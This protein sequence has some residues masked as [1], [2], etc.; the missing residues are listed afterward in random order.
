MIDNKKKL[1]FGFLVDSI[2]M[3]LLRHVLEGIR[4]SCKANNIKLLIYTGA[5]SY[6]K[7]VTKALYNLVSRYIYKLDVDGLMVFT[8][9]IAAHK[10]L[11]YVKKIVMAIKDIPV[12]SISTE[13]PGYSSI[14]V[15]NEMGI[16]QIFDHLHNDHGFKRIAFIKGPKDHYES[17]LRYNTYCNSLYKYGISL[18]ENIIIQGERF[19]EPTGYK[20]AKKLL[21]NIKNIDAIMAADDYIAIGAIKCLNDNN[22]SVPNDITVTGFDNIVTTKFSK[23]TLTTVEQPFYN[24][25]VQSVNCMMNIINYGDKKE[26]IKLPTKLIL[27]DSCCFSECKLR[28]EDH[29]KYIDLNKFILKKSEKFIKNIIECLQSNSLKNI[30]HLTSI[31][32]TRLLDDYNK[33]ISLS[34]WP[35]IIK[36]LFSRLENKTMSWDFKWALIRTFNEILISF[37]ELEKQSKN[38]RDK[39]ELCSLYYLAHEIL[40][41]FNKDEL[42]EI[43]YMRLLEFNIKNFYLC[44]YDREYSEDEINKKKELPIAT[45]QLVHN[46]SLNI[47]N[48]KGLNISGESVLSDKILNVESELNFYPIY[49]NSIHFGYILFKLDKNVMTELYDLLRISIGSALHSCYIM[50]KL[51]N[52]VKHKTNFLI[53]LTHEMKTPLTI[54]SSYLGKYILE[55]KDLNDISI[56]INNVDKL[57]RDINNILDYE[58]LD[59]G[60]VHY[61]NLQKINLSKY[62]NQK[63]TSF[64]E[65]IKRSRIT[66]IKNIRNTCYIKM[67]PAALD[68]VLNNLIE[69]AIKYNIPDGVIGVSLY[70][71]DNYIELE[72]FNTGQLIHKSDESRIFDPFYQKNKEKSN[73]DGIGMGLSLVREIVERANCSIKLKSKDEKTCFVVRFPIANHDRGI[74]KDNLVFDIKIP[75]TLPSQSNKPKFDPSNNTILIVEDNQQMLHFLQSQLNPLYNLYSSYSANE[76]LILLDKIPKPDIIISDMMMDG[77]SGIDFFELLQRKSRFNDI[78]FLFLSANNRLETKIQ[79]LKMGAVDY[80]TKPFRLQLLL[81]KIESLLKLY[82]IQKNKAR[83]KLKKDLY[84]FLDDDKNNNS[85]IIPSQLTKIFAKRELDAIK[86]IK[87][88]MLYKEIASEMDIS[89]NT[90]KTYMKRIY[91]KAGVNNKVELLNKLKWEGNSL[92]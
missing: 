74:E 92:V 67:D 52:S 50:N 70:V 28:Q 38:D 65:I 15:D 75:P 85:L 11:D 4:S 51:E 90:L 29:V 55:P 21:N 2:D 35:I 76:A 61:N 36:E 56:V 25:G 39:K 19:G 84:L 14:L 40:S 68:R 37:L 53:N 23:P 32:K 54:I 46:E 5:I 60:K 59:K 79:A 13:I 27:R 63:L 22:I 33:Q 10:G 16:S 31:L 12:I 82:N 57:T 1:R 71:V 49:F 58:R 8:G 26:V 86:Y 80:I 17:E 42:L 44:L 18:N 20:A 72:I 47:G 69:N 3:D 24:L 78:P 89:I 81:Y 9:G 6:D 73:S 83:E 66:Y 77:M 64:Q 45:L 62:L 43:L 91:S 30:P 88:G 7:C 34:C 48:L 41:T 87:K